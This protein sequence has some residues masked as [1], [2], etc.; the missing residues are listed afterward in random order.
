MV[1]SPGC[2]LETGIVGASL[3]VGRWVKKLIQRPKDEGL[4][5]NPGTA[6]L[7]LEGEGIS[8]APYHQEQT[9]VWGEW[10]MEGESRR[11]QEQIWGRGDE[12]R[13]VHG[14]HGCA[15]V[16][17][18]PGNCCLCPVLSSAASLWT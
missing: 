13:G 9:L 6:A 17:L 18:L 15:P 14:V 5:G 11:V 2:W 16:A 10:G 8:S 7:G 1:R 4:M 3:E 12:F